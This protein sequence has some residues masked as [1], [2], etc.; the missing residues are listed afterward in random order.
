MFQDSAGLAMGK[1]NYPFVN[2]P[3]LSVEYV[4]YMRSTDWKAKRLFA[5]HLAG[6]RC[7][8]CGGR[9]RLQVHHNTYERFGHELMSDLI[10]LCGDCH[11]F[12][13]LFL[14]M[15]RWFRVVI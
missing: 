13:T 12:A 3:R 11:H 4:R 10:V 1:T 14:R 2:R 8:L 6:Y 15:R 5:L 7:Q 9:G